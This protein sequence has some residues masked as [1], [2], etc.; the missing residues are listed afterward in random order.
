M[1]KVDTFLKELE[2]LKSGMNKNED[3]LTDNDKL[4]ILERKQ[5]ELGRKAEQIQEEIERE[6]SDFFGYLNMKQASIE[7]LR[8]MNEYIED[9]VKKVEQQIN[10]IKTTK[11]VTN[12]PHE[13]NK[14]TKGA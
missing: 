4:F 12:Q 1:K 14:L 13:E 5:K 6:V 11:N 9:E 3:Q 2:G 10:N 7:T 8:N